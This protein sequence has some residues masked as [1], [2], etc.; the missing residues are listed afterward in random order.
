[1]DTYEVLEVFSPGVVLG[2]AGIHSLDDGCYVS[3]N[4][5]VH[6][7]CREKEEHSS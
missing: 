2:P 6:Q 4:Q 7:C 5:G 1:M 3:K